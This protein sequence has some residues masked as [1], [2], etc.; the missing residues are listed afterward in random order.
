MIRSPMTCRRLRALLICGGLIAV[1][2][3]SALAASSIKGVVRNLTR[4]RF[5][6]GAEV[7]LFRL[8]QTGLNQHMQEETRTKADSQGLFTLDVRY[9]DKLHLVRIVHQ[10]V[11]YDRQA[12]AGDDVSIDVFDAIAKVQGVTASED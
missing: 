1:C 12:S 11:N 3:A 10:G 8:D 2:S 6:A 9:P 5:A 4:G 7:T